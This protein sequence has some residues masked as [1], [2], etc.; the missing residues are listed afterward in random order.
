MTLTEPH[1]DPVHVNGEQHG[2]LVHAYTVGWLNL[3]N[4]CI[5]SHYRFF[6]L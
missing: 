1:P 6:V 5:A 3:L 4:M 2:A